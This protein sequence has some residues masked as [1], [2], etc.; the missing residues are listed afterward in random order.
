MWGGGSAAEAQ[1]VRDDK[2]WVVAGVDESKSLYDMKDSRFLGRWTGDG[3][4]EETLEGDVTGDKVFD[5]GDN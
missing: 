1:V 5:W 3:G 4:C 2:G